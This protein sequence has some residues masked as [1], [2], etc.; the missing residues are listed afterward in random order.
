MNFPTRDATRQMRKPNEIH[1]VWQFLIRPVHPI[2][3]LTTFQK[4]HM[5]KKHDERIRHTFLG[6][7]LT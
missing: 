6:G 4:I 5:A 7:E 2:S 1:S 3:K